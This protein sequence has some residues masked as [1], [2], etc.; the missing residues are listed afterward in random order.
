M[1]HS[2][3]RKSA[4]LLPAA[5]ALSGGFAGGLLRA[6]F[7]GLVAWQ[8]RE[9]ERRQLRRLTDHQLKDMGL[10]RAEAEE[11][12]RRAVWSRPL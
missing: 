12:A 4:P 10:T 6:L 9:E 3:I 11:M 7:D 8:R 5:S 2:A 1:E